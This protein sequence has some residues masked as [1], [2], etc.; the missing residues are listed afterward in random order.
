MPRVLI[1]GGGIGGLVTALTMHQIGVPCTVFETVRELRPKGVGLNLQPNAVRELYDLGVAGASLNSVGVPLQEWSLVARNGQVIVSEPRGL[2]A[3]YRW[4][5]FSVDRGLLHMLLY[6]LVVRRMGAETVVLGARARGYRQSG[7]QVT[8]LL[9]DGREETGDVLIGA[10]GIHS[11]IR[12]QMYPDQPPPNWGGAVLWRGV[13][14]AKPLRGRSTFIGTGAGDKRVAVFPISHLGSDGLARINWIGGLRIEDHAARRHGSWFNPVD[15]ASFT[16]LF[17]DW[18]L[19][20]IDVPTLMRGADAVYENPLLDRDPVPTWRDGRVV[21]LGDAAH[22]MLPAG[23]NGASQAIIDARVLGAA[24]V[25]RG[26]T[27]RALHHYDD[28]LCGPV[29]ALVMRN[30][31]EGPF[32]LLR[33]VEARGGS[34]FD[35]IDAVIPQA[36]RDEFMARYKIASGFAREVLNASPPLIAP[37]AQVAPRL[38]RG[39]PPPPLVAQ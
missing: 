12:A 20:W 19:D 24:M 18:A 4:P 25:E 2:V 16:P 21:L 32:E 28:Q 35:S 30:R 11:A 10:D 5:Q 27:A 8:L 9:D 33:I 37:G 31:D 34:D 6:H 26:V 17:E 36:E 3:G 29:S 13:T 1:A 39:R 23:S 7:R 22:P 15:A 38:T 14:R